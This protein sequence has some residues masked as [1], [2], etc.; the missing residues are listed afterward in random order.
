MASLA[1]GTDAPAFLLTARAPSRHVAE[2]PEDS[3][4]LVAASTF[5]ISNTDHLFG[6][7]AVHHKILS[8]DQSSPG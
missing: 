1:I 7:A 5:A 8:G 6:H 2:K 4:C 3:G